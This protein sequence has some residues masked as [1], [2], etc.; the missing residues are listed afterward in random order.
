MT[1]TASLPYVEVPAKRSADKVPV[2]FDWHDYLAN[3]WQRGT[4][5][6]LGARIRPE[7]LQATGLEYEVTTGGV[8]GNRRPN[9]PVTLS[10]TVQSGSVV[11]TAR[12]MSDSSLRATILSST[13]PAVDGLT[14]SDQS[15]DDHVHTIF[16]AAGTSGQHYDVAN[17]ITLSNPP[18]ELKEGVARLMVQD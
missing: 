4:P 11:F 17:R 18:G 12:E 8:S 6:L 13:F 16:V 10:E 7:R 1:D 3:K 9:F 14:L 2:Q 5:Y 15:D